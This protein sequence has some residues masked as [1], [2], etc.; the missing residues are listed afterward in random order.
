ML[1][2]HIECEWWNLIGCSTRC[3]ILHFLVLSS[4]WSKFCRFDNSSKFKRWMKCDRECYHTNEGSFLQTLVTY[5]IPNSTMYLGK[6]Q[7]FNLWA[8]VIIVAGDFCVYVILWISGT[9]YRCTHVHDVQ[10]TYL[11]NYIFLTI[12]SFVCMHRIYSLD[13]YVYETYIDLSCSGFY[14]NSLGLW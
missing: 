5:H 12:K 1:L 9:L 11:V 10:C 14:I 7:F 8:S 3:K 13:M 4:F 2:W 6:S